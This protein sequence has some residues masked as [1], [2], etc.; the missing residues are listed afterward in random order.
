MKDTLKINLHDG[1]QWNINLLILGVFK[2]E[3][4]LEEAGSSFSVG[5]GMLQNVIKLILLPL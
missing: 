4:Y 3:F 2:L 1:L 5:S